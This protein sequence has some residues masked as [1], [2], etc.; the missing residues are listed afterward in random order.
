[1]VREWI[2]A[3]GL[4]YGSKCISYG[5]QTPYQAWRE[6]LAA[7]CDL[8]PQPQPVHDWLALPPALS[9]WKTHP[10]NLAI[11]PLLPC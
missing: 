2:M 6:V 5:R 3:G 1:M 11:G 9:I 8:T 4:G 10:V 7:V